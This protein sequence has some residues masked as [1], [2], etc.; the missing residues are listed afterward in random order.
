LA[1]WILGHAREHRVY[2]EP[3]LGGGSVWLAKVPSPVEILNDLNPALS[4]LWRVLKSPELFPALLAR[5]RA[6]PFG[7]ESWR[8][9]RAQLT[10]RPSDP[11]DRAVAYFVCSRLSRGGQGQSF[12]TPT[13]R[14]R[15][16]LPE[17][18]SAWLSA[19]ENLPTIHE[20]LQ[21]ATLLPPT[22]TLEVIRQYDGADALIYCDP[23]YVAATRNGIGQYGDYEMSNDDHRQLLAALRQCRGQVLLSGYRSEL[24]D[25]AL[26]DWNCSE[27]P[28]PADSAGGQAKGRRTECLWQNRRTQSSACSFK[29]PD[30]FEEDGLL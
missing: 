19:I 27:K 18:E 20:R 15:R 8:D 5:V 13:T 4:N 3:F 12:L 30:A 6:T 21:G 17:H 14:T 24:Y 25:E 2:V 9:A 22:P 29:P 7:I 16:G 1:R 23:P 28:M 11:L 26:R 10:G